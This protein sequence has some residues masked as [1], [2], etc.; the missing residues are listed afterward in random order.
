MRFLD[1]LFT[2]KSCEHVH[3]MFTKQYVVNIGYVNQH[4]NVF[5]LYVHC[6]HFVNM[7][8]SQTYFPPKGGIFVVNIFCEH[9]PKNQPVPPASQIFNQEAVCL[10]T[11]SL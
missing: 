2:R 4:Y 1:D 7:S 3:G 9:H 5:P 6:E 10:K 8:C 11:N